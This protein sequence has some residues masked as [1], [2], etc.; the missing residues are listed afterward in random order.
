MPETK[1]LDDLLADLRSQRAS[2]SVI[3]DEFGRTAG[4]VTIEDIIEE[5]VGEIVDETDPLLSAVR[6]LVNG[7]WFVRGHVSLG[8]LEDVG[9]KLPVDSD[10]YTTIGGYVFGELGRLPK[11]GDQIIANG[12]QIRVEAVRENRVEAVRIHPTAQPAASQP[13]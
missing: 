6:Q 3:V 8:D 12:Y 4:I 5:I 7:D 9:I 11:R 2:L 1:P 10:A 13:Q